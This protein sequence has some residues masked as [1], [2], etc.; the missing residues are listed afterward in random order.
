MR[1]AEK[2]SFGVNSYFYKLETG[3]DTEPDVYDYK[4]DFEGFEKDKD[5]AVSGDEMDG[6]DDLSGFGEGADLG[7]E[8]DNSSKNEES[9][10]SGP[11]ATKFSASRIPGL[12]ERSPTASTSLTR[13]ATSTINRDRDAEDSDS[14]ALSSPPSSISSFSMSPSPAPPALA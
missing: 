5:L 12:V 8:E 9:V 14:S 4:K 1:E 10:I 6:I 2:E 11:V 13:S 3:L 7:I